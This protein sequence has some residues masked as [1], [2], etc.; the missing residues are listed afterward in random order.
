MRRL[1]TRLPPRFLRT[2]EAARFLALSARTLEKHRCYGTGPKYRKLGG[3][4]IYALEDLRAWA[5]LVIKKST[6]HPGS[7]TVLPARPIPAAGCSLP[8]TTARDGRQRPSASEAGPVPDRP[9]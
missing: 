2:S 6:S 5:N 7:G 3:R 9:E 4:V 8:Q 1:L